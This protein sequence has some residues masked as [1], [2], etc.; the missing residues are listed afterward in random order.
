M[1]DAYGQLDSSSLRPAMA[2]VVEINSLA[3]LQ[4]YATAWDSLAQQTPRVSFFHTF[5]W[6]NTFWKHFGANRRMRV[7][8]V[9]SEETI[10]G[11]VPLCVAEEA[12]RLAK[13]RVL[14][15]P[16]NDWGMWAGPLGPNPS[17]TMFMALQHIRDTDRDWDMIDF[18]WTSEYHDMT[19]RAM[20]AVGWKPQK[21][22]FQQTSLIEFDSTDWQTY[23]NGLN[24]KWRHEIRRQTR[25]LEKTG[26][27]EFVRYRPTV[28]EGD[29]RWDLFDE[30]LTVSRRSWQADAHNGNT[31]CH[32]DVLPFLKDCHA[33]ASRLGMLDV[34]I[35]RV[36]GQPLAYQYNYHHAG[37][38]FGLRMGYDRQARE[39]GAGK[40]LLARFIEDSFQRGDHVLDLGIGE[41]DFKA[42]FRT[43]VEQSYRYSYYPWNSWRSQGIR[44]TQWLRQQL[45]AEE[46]VASKP[47]PAVSA[48]SS[49]GSDV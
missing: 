27:V 2:D 11:I 17:A 23:F 33:E 16:L 19:G 9:R 5:S 15:Y 29:P 44:I 38:I 10:V 21:S 39:L 24:K 8:V 31:I 7:L 26:L 35:L 37:N 6:F 43:G 40:V 12:H 30:C 4:S 41:F 18:R 25:N 45:A 3:E 28:G 36:A 32:A 49:P 1:N 22:V 42:R 48:L 47:A 34:A 13:V 14:N 20:S 46:V